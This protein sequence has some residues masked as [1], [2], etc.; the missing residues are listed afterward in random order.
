[1]GKAENRLATGETDEA[2]LARP[3]CRVAYPSTLTFSFE[4]YSNSFWHS[5]CNILADFSLISPPKLAALGGEGPFR[6]LMR[7]APS[8]PQGHCIERAEG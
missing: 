7:V 4:R 1:M 2:Q 3:A 5:S 8:A 6:F